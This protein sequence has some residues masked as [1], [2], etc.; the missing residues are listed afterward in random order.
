MLPRSMSTNPPLRWRW[1]LVGG[2]WADATAGAAITYY[3]AGSNG[4]VEPVDR[5]LL[6]GY[7][8]LTC[9]VLLIP[10]NL[11]L[12]G[13]A[14]R[15]IS[16]RSEQPPDRVLTTSVSLHL[17]TLVAGYG[18]SVRASHWWFYERA[19]L[20]ILATPNLLVAAGCIAAAIAV[21]AALQF[22]WRLQERLKL[23]IRVWCGLTTMAV[24]LA[25]FTHVP[26]PP[27][28]PPPPLPRP[29]PLPPPEFQVIWI[30]IDG[31]DWEILDP[32]M[33]AGDL[34]NLEGLC[35]R[36]VRGPL[37]SIPPYASHPCWVT[38]ATGAAPETHGI[39]TRLMARFPGVAPFNVRY[40]TKEFLP[41][42]QAGALLIRLGIAEAVPPPRYLWRAE[43]VW[44]SLS[45]AG[46]SCAIIGWP[47]TWPPDAI[48]GLVVSDR[49][50]YSVWE[51]FY[52]H[53]AGPPLNVHP[54][55][56]LLRA[57]A[58][59][60]DPRRFTADDAR[61]FFD[62]SP[63][64]V[65]RFRAESMN[66]FFRDRVACLGRGYAMDRTDL[67]IANE[68]LTEHPRR[69]DLVALYIAGLDMATHGFWIEQDPGRFAGAAPS[70]RPELRDVLPRYCRF[71][72]AEIGALMR[73][74]AANSVVLITSDHGAAPTP[75]HP[76][77]PAGHDGDGVFLIAGPP[78]RA[79]A[80]IEGARL[81]D[82]A[83]TVSYLLGAPPPAQNEG[84]VL[85]ACFTPDHLS[86]FPPPAENP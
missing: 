80:R 58:L 67:S 14:S 74:A 15:I 81:Q 57:R 45:R 83:S 73:R 49:F 84:R 76:V 30:G 5:M 11:L 53:T 12:S 7:G 27:G 75:H 60:A 20:G 4:V 54:E 56:W 17:A 33:A 48:D 3:F 32:L 2:L 47:S 9:A 69:P 50:Y 16:R 29:A 25:P 38:A 13:I 1:A 42:F 31:A 24:L 6:M 36:G 61:L 65:D 18:L 23:R 86:S 68:V 43:P 46:R 41:I 71:L 55:S 82:L 66:A 35:R 19:K 40:Q 34:P 64:L 26:P 59:R 22:L 51:A 77:W 62:P 44:M 78:V 21:Y 37:K 39:G 10:L 63:D 70:G 72:D 28:L 52:R 8:A 85:R 79:G